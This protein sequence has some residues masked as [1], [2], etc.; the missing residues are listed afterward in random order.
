[1]NR[2]EYEAEIEAK[3]QRMLERAERADR[4]AREAAAAAGAIADRIPMGQPILVGHRSERRHRRDL[5]RIDTN[6][7]KTSEAAAHAQDLRRRAAKLGSTISSEDPGAIE[8]LE[9]KL[10]DLEESRETM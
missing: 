6:M 1:M 4:E 2:D 3:R 10:A 9:E 7:R 8:K 5:E